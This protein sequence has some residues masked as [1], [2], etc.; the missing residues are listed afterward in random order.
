MPLASTQASGTATD[1]TTEGKPGIGQGNLRISGPDMST[2]HAFDN[3][4]VIML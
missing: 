3:F 2:A 1:Y 4:R